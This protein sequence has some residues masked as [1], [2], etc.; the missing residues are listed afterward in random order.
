LLEHRA[1]ILADKAINDKVSKD[2]W[3]KVCDELVVGIK[4]KNLGD[5][6]VSTIESCGRIM[7]PHFP[8][9]HDDTNELKNH[10]VI[11]E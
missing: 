8:I 1:V 10:L 4:T 5:A 3:E 9:Q 7:T 2:T 6:M 11:K